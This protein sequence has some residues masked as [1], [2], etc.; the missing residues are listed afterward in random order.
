[1]KHRNSYLWCHFYTNLPKIQYSETILT[2]LL[3]FCGLAI[4]A[5]LI[6]ALC[7]F[8]WFHSCVC[9]YWQVCWGTVGPKW[10]HSYV[11]QLAETFGWGN[12]VLL[13]MVSSHVQLRLPHVAHWL[14][15]SGV[16]SL[17]SLERSHQY[18]SHCF[19][20]AQ[21][22]PQNSR[23]QSHSLL[24]GKALTSHCKEESCQDKK[25]LQATYYKYNVFINILIQIL[26]F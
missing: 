9:G 22:K 6:S 25:N 4:S 17:V 19:F 16:T 3:K 21:S 2:C 24:T 23:Q 7:G 13:Y 11:Q 1:M 18:Q 8:G 20:I 5:G 26:Y 14:Q 15:D 10:P 12:L